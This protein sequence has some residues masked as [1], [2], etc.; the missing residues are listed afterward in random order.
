[1]DTTSHTAKTTARLHATVSRRPF[2]L[3]APRQDCV[4]EE[5]IAEGLS[6]YPMYEGDIEQSY[7]LA[8]HALEVARRSPSRYRMAALIYFAPAVYLRDPTT[9][10]KL[11]DFTT[12][13]RVRRAIYRHFGLPADLD[14][15]AIAAIRGAEEK[16]TAA[17]RR[18][19]LGVRGTSNQ[20][21][22]PDDWIIQP[23]D[24]SQAK[25]S[26]TN[27]IRLLRISQ[28]IEQE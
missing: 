8:Q 12:E 9:P 10:R 16:V 2:S 24:A 17:E 5:L 25:T 21:S 14:A 11:D 15:D 27:Y 13:Q 19:L 3:R 22:E 23:L 1:M 6:R 4:S 20:Q 18:D 26:F 7:S 28:Q